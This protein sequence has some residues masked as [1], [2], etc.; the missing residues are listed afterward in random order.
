MV[1]FGTGW[2]DGKAHQGSQRSS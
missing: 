1:Q 2:E